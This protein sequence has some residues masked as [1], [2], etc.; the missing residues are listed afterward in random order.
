MFVLRIDS[1]TL[2]A[3]ACTA[4]T[5]VTHSQQFSLAK[6]SRGKSFIETHYNFSKSPA[7]LHV[8]L[9]N[10]PSS[11]TLA[12]QLSLLSSAHVKTAY[13]AICFQPSTE[14][15]KISSKYI[16]WIFQKTKNIVGLGRR[17][18]RLAVGGVTEMDT[19]Y[20][21][22]A[23]RLLQQQAGT[24]AGFTPWGCFRAQLSHLSLFGKILTLNGNLQCC[25][26][27]RLTCLIIGFIHLHKLVHFWLH[28]SRVPCRQIVCIQSI[29]NVLKRMQIS[30]V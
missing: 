22:F 14:K 6:E 3:L 13:L 7:L 10:N 29:L 9:L 24:S 16:C 20:F 23:S 4:R 5:P 25:P 2:F 1:W 12:E 8:L 19:F 28:F 17:S 21:S 18:Q 27:G 30:F 15:K 11:A 26:Q